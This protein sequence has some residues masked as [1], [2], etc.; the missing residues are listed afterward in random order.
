M[1]EEMKWFAV[2]VV[3]STACGATALWKTGLAWL[4]IGAFISIFAI[5]FAAAWQEQKR[6]STS[7]E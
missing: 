5:V 4:A 1:S 6:R 2:A 7:N 3:L